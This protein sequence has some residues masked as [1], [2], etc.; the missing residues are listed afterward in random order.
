M[1]A[2]LLENDVQV[3]V[4]LRADEHHRGYDSED[5]VLEREA[6]VRK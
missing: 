1:I 3:T 5:V 4:V 2:A 6:R